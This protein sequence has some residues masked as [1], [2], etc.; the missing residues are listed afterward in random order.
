MHLLRL[1]LGE[2]LLFIIVVALHM[3]IN[4]QVTDGFRIVESGSPIVTH[5]HHDRADISQA[6][7]LLTMVIVK[8]AIN[9]EGVRIA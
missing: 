3:H 5:L 8:L 9:M 2:L 6:D 4:D 1:C 7:A